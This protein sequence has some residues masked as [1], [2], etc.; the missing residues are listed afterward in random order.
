MKNSSLLGLS[1]ELSKLKK[2]P[3]IS[4]KHIKS[5]RRSKNEYY[6]I[7]S[8]PEKR[9]RN[10]FSEHKRPYPN[11]YPFYLPIGPPP[12][13]YPPY[14]LPYMQMPP[15][16]SW[17]REEARPMEKKEEP[18]KKS[19]DILRNSPQ[20]KKINRFRVVAL[21]VYFALY[22]RSYSKKFT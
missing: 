9:S 11:M 19:K 21:A 15:S 12:M 1:Q 10:L 8:E 14:F 20:R 4:K 7:E 3:Q 6:S 16:D 17:K 5:S 18:L 2:L 13:Q 22:F